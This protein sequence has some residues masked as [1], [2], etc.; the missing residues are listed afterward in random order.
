MSRPALFS[1]EGALRVLGKHDRPWLDAT[2]TFL[3]I[4]I[5]V[6]GA[7]E[8]DV[9]DLVDPKNEATACV[10]KVLDGITNK[11]TG[12]SGTQRHELIAAAHTIIAV[13]SVFDAFREEI[14]QDFTQL[15]ITDREK[16]RI[17]KVEPP[18]KKKEVAALPRLTSLDVP[19]PNATRGFYENLNDNLEKF[20]HQAVELAGAFVRGLENPPRRIGSAEF[21]KAVTARCAGLYTS[22]YLGLASAIPEFFI[23]ALLGEN[24]ATRSKIGEN[25]AELLE[26]LTSIRTESLELLSQLLTKLSSPP[27]SP[28]EK[29]FRKL[30]KLT[31]A[32]LGRLLIG[33]DVDPS[34]VDA[35][36]PTVED[37]FIAPSY[38]FTVYRKET[39]A[40]S[41]KWWR[42]NTAIREDLDT[43]LAAHLAGEES[44]TRP[45]LVLGEPGAGKSLL[46]DVLAA[47]LHPDRFTVITVP[48]RSVRPEDSLKDQIDTVLHR[49]V[50]K[51]FGWDQLS[52]E[53]GDRLPVILLDG[54][55]ELIQASGVH[56]SNYL[57]QVQEFQKHQTI[58]ERP[59]AVVVTS[60]VLVA[61][62]AQIPFDVPIVKLEE[63][64]DDRIERWL[65][66]WNTANLDTP[67]FRP[68]T[69][70]ALNQHLELASQPLLL[71]M[72]AI[73][74]A[75]PGQAPLDDPDLSNAELYRRLINS[76]VVRQVGYKGS[77]TPSPDII[78]KL[79]AKSA[80]RLG[81]A[82]FAMFNRGHQYVTATELKQD[83]AVFEQ[84]TPAMPSTTF[85]TPIDD[86]D[87]TVE[88]FFFIH[89]P[90]LRDGTMLAGRTYEFL[91]ATFGEFLIAEVTMKL[92]VRLAAA[93]ARHA[94]DPDEEPA[95]DD[96]RLFALISHQ[97]FVKRRPIIDF[98]QGLY[99]ALPDMDRAAVLNTLDDLIRTLHDRPLNDPYSTYKPA[100]ATFVSRLATYSANL[101]CL[102]VFLG[103]EGPTP[104]SSL[105]AQDGGNPLAG[106]RSTV[107]LWKSGLDSEG[108][109]A[110]LAIITLEETD[111]WYIVEQRA[112]YPGYG[113]PEAKLLGDPVQEALLKTGAP[114][115]DLDV[116]SDAQEQA[117]L[118]KFS[119][120]LANTSGSGCSNHAVP[121]DVDDLAK[122][123]HSAESG[124]R[125]NESARSMITRALSREASRLPRRLVERGLRLLAPVSP[126]DCERDSV[127]PFELISMMCAHP[128]L[129]RHGVFPT[130]LLPHMLNDNPSS[131]L[132]SLVLTWTALNSADSRIDDA[133]RK[134][135]GHVEEAAV[136]H[137]DSV[138]SAYLP[139]EAFEYLAHPRKTEPT[140][141]SGLLGTLRRI[142]QHAADEVSPRT[143]LKLVERFQPRV[144]ELETA[145]FVSR[146]LDGRT[147]EETAQ[148]LEALEVLRQMAD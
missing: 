82:A 67:G 89:S 50:S 136:P 24:A 3:G 48:L 26:R 76:F 56:Q 35:A 118:A 114:F 146:Y 47:R 72:L 138:G 1:Y 84:A 46:M 86:A 107:N 140:F 111:T 123:L 121:Y 145:V 2:D 71:L 52:D 122:I 21:L 103:H 13:T 25:H 70:A 37:G 132:S 104:V 22:H 31:E 144:D 91:H 142:V 42:D 101:V 16:F 93:R 113:V 5:L 129:A 49:T 131:A 143:V 66:A 78:T 34:S 85:D 45:L 12:L 59:V 100:S 120:W 98:A 134:F 43:F 77:E 105:F 30:R 19:A 83:L 39:V 41:R 27:P 139:V 95:P 73:Y 65:A 20:F 80:R 62:R 79:A 87:R 147:V 10:R 28:N 125:L 23:W 9:L 81:I 40:S 124:V 18:D 4:G 64:D 135:S 137:V 96:S 60:R 112:M 44:T 54:F 74:A 57:K 128:D 68:L 106:W 33:P 14:G 61:D 148:D 141:D 88:N 51:S 53:C 130:E 6:G 92:L 69:L 58:T 110:I 8:P 116:T 117:L 133:F 15:K 36:F 29:Y 127:L 109:R 99:D 17:F 94:A 115:V 75:D 126:E 90:K 32:T 102:R 38:R 119:S 55:D 108:W 11:L 97:A 63:F 7:V